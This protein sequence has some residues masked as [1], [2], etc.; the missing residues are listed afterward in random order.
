MTSLVG[1]TGVDTATVVTLESNVFIGG[2]TGDDIITTALGTGGNNL[3]GYTVRGG[4]GDDT[5]TLG[6]S[7]LSSTISLDG[8]TLANDGND[9]LAGAG[10]LIINSS[11]VGRGGNDTINGVQLNGSTVNGNTGN[12]TITIQA[13]S[14]STVYGGQG[15]DVITN[16]AATTNSAI[17]INGNKGSDTV[18]LAAASFTGSVYG[19]AGSDTL[20][21]AAVDADAAGTALAVT[22]T[23]V[24]LSGDLGADNITGSTGID[25]INGGEGADT[26][27][28]GTGA[29]TIDSGAGAD[30]VTGSA[31]ADA[32]TGGAGNDIFVYTTLTDSA[33]T[34]A[35]SSTGFDTISDFASN[36]T[37]AATQA[38]GNGDLFD[39]AAAVVTA[40]DAGG[41]TVA[42]NTAA[43]ANLAATL[44]TAFDTSLVANG[45]GTINITGSTAFSGTYLVINDGD[46]NFTFAT[47]AVVKLNTVASISADSFI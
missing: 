4:G 18:T 10:N 46:T 34:S 22:G 38:T 31:G 15:V 44:D 23:G 3:S 13:S 21:A 45:V 42:G 28:G 2:N 19:G 25:T 32:I 29:D 8:E 16:T 40:V 11:I 1:T 27:V 20:S 43:G 39:V 47:D 41:I 12:D 36:T 5:I 30:S 17:L 33:L 9:T 7:V 26:I 24:F 6:D 14:A 35:A 37:A